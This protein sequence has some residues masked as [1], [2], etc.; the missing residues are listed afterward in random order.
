MKTFVVNFDNIRRT[1]RIVI[2]CSVS[3]AIK[4]KYAQWLYPTRIRDIQQKHIETVLFHSFK[5]GN[6][7]WYLCFS[8]CHLL[9]QKRI[10][11]FAL[12]FTNLLLSFW[13][14]RSGQYNVYCILTFNVQITSLH[15][16]SMTVL[17]SLHCPAVSQQF[18]YDIL[19]ENVV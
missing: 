13:V 3:Q 10:K 14:K 12:V 8:K 9:R 16:D 2:R 6:K 11:L 19:R 5:Y 15:T 7:N 17:W 1:F 18:A 4:V